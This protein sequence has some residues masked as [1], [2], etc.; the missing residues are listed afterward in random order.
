MARP[1]EEEKEEI[2][3]PPKTVTAVKKVDLVLVSYVDHNGQKVTQLALVGEQHVQLLNNLDYGLG[4]VRTQKG[5]AN[6]WLTRGIFEQ[7][8]RGKAK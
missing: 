2:P 1:K 3:P 6:S 8:P 7:L 5:P 4:E